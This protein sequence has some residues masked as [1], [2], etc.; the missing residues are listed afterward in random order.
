MKQIAQFFLKLF[1][2]KYLHI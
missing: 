1:D 2:L